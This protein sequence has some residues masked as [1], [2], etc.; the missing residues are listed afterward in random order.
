MKDHEIAKLVNELRDIAQTY[1]QSQQLRQRIHGVVVSHLKLLQWLEVQ[2]E[3]W[4]EEAERLVTLDPKADTPD[5]VRLALLAEIVEN[6]EK[7]RYPFPVPKSKSQLKR[8]LGMTPARMKKW[9]TKHGDPDLAD[10]PVGP[11]DKSPLSN[12]ERKLVE[13]LEIARD[14]LTAEKQTNLPWDMDSVPL[15]KIGEALESIHRP[16]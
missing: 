3:A 2:Q 12:R 1:G 11:S 10:I 7:Q 13:A 4:R 8:F 6:Y 9:L 14:F 16:V 15:N 5:G